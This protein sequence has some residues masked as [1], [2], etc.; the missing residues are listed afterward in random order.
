M[1]LVE[2]FYPI[3]EGFYFSLV[4][5]FLLV[6]F[7]IEAKTD[8]TKKYIIIMGICGIATFVGSTLDQ[9][10]DN[11]FFKLITL[12]SLQGVIYSYI[13]VLQTDRRASQSTGEIES[14]MYGPISPALSQTGHLIMVVS[15]VI[16]LAFLII[17]DFIV[18]IR[19]LT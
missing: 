11:L 10:Y 2:R 15:A 4:F 12:I 7:W 13:R 6:L 5:I 14:S 3:S 19:I 16:V 17:I 1:V 18:I 8:L 9:R